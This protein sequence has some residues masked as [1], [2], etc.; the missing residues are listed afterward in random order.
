M[1]MPT[2]VAEKSYRAGACNICGCT[3]YRKTHYFAEWNLGRDPVKDV[4]II[5][6]SDCKVRRRMPE[7]IDNY[8]SDYHASYVE[9]GQAIH[10]GQLA[11]FTDLMTARLR[12]LTA[13][14]I[15]FL[16]VGCSTGRALRMAST[17]GFHATGLDFSRWAAEY[18]AKLGFVTRQ[19]SLIGQWTEAGMFDVVHC[20]HTIEHV[21]DPVAYLNEMHRLLKP[22]G[23]LMLA[24]P[25]YASLPR[26]M[27]GKDWGIW[28][29]DSHLWQFTRKQMCTLLKNAG[30]TLVS[31][32]T[33]HG[34]TPDNPWKKR[35]L[36]W[37]SIFGFGDGLNIIAAR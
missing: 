18:C 26:L 27:K 33:V 30:F 25:N 13:Q 34:Y 21:P 10:P 29:L 8:E 9:Q 20:C 15:S 37:A 12:Q 24:C 31:V 28:C 22:G 3:T 6:C 4:S 11:H 32:H 19:G 1:T 17:L 7:I 23:H 2:Q 5:Q 35:L 16:D 36:D 14:N